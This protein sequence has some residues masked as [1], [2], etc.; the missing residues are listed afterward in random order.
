M[1][2][3]EYETLCNGILSLQELCSYPYLGLPGVA[4]EIESVGASFLP[5]A[6]FTTS[7]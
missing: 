4:L 3:I 5:F 7:F 2:S 1:K 6:Y